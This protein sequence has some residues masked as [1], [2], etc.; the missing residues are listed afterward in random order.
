MMTYKIKK[1]LEITYIS[2]ISSQ[3]FIGGDLSASNTAASQA[4]PEIQTPQPGLTT[5]PNTF[6][7]I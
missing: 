5:A 2:T 6:A 4:K 1:F 3:Q 7:A